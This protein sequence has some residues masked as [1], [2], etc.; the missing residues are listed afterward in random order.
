M[1]SPSIWRYELSFNDFHF[2]SFTSSSVFWCGFNLQFKFY[3]C[4]L[5]SYS[6]S[7]SN[8]FK[9]FEKIFRFFSFICWPWWCQLVWPSSL[10]VII[11]LLSVSLW[12]FKREVWGCCSSSTHLHHHFILV[13]LG[14]S[15]RRES[16]RKTGRNWKKTKIMKIRLLPYHQTTFP[17]WFFQ[18]WS[19]Y[20]WDLTRCEIGKCKK[21]QKLT[22]LIS[23]AH[24]LKKN[25]LPGYTPE[26]SGHGHKFLGYFGLGHG[27]GQDQ[28]FEFGNRFVRMENLKVK[29]WAAKLWYRL[30]S[31]VI[32]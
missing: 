23:C 5:S 13:A 10:C 8:F 31:W 26:L 21:L 14:S 25:R 2:L 7:S 18:I 15:D 19:P 28:K 22:Y 32:F 29:L 4:L 17:A 11:Y 16:E 20:L 24:R 12:A 30:I 3:F 27:L 6:S 1:S 9:I